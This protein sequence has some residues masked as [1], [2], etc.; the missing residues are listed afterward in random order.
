MI[1]AR[2]DLYQRVDNLQPEKNKLRRLQP[3]GKK[4]REIK[5]VVSFSPQR[6]Y[7]EFF[8]MFFESNIFEKKNNKLRLP[9]GIDLTQ[10]QLCLYKNNF[11]RLAFFGLPQ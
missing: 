5:H 1:V 10:T 11:V 8:R 9:I 4:T 2:V 3:L 6:R 7:E